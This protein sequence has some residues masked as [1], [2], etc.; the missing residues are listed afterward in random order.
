MSVFVVNC[1]LVT[2]VLSNQLGLKGALTVLSIS[3]IYNL[4]QE[5]VKHIA[6]IY[7]KKKKNFNLTEIMFSLCL[8]IQSNIN[9]T[10]S[11]GGCWD[12]F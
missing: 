7:V 10:H 5:I 1:I 6:L 11:L 4:M 2:P 9:E 8:T 3:T 12:A